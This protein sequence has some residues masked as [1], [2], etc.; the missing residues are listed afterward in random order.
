MP[1]TVNPYKESDSTKKQQVEEMFD[2]ISGKYDF[3]NRFFSLGIDVIWRKKAVRY[4]KPFNP[5][6]ITE[7]MVKILAD[8]TYYNDLS[9]K[10]I[11]RNQLFSWKNMAKEY[12]KLY[13]EVNLK[14]KKN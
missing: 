4:L 6:E 3:L 1:T 8:S 11:E 10:G 13:S 7:A 2:N 14:Q 5:K 9:K 12:L